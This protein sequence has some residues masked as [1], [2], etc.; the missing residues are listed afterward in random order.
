VCLKYCIKILAELVEIIIIIGSTAPG[1]GLDLLK[2][3][4]NIS[5]NSCVHFLCDALQIGKVL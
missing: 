1:V 2:V 4:G 5:Q 3:G